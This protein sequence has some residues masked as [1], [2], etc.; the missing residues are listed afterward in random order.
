[1]PFAS[2]PVLVAR[3]PVAVEVAG[4]DTVLDEPLE[5]VG[6]DG[7]SD[8][9]VPPELVEA[10]DPAERV[11]QD[12]DGPTVA[13]DIQ[14]RL[15]RAASSRGRSA[16]ARMHRRSVLIPNQ[17]G[18]EPEPTLP[19]AKS[20][21]QFGSTRCATAGGS[22]PW[23][24]M[25]DEVLPQEQD[26]DHDHE[27]DARAPP[28]GAPPPRRDRRDRPRH[29]VR[30]Q[31]MVWSRTSPSSSAW[32]PPHP[33]GRACS[34]P[35]WPGCSPGRPPWPRGEYV[36]MRA[37]SELVER[38]LEIERR[39]LHHQPEA[40]TRELASIYRTAGPRRRPGRGTGR[41]RHGRP[42]RRARGPRPAR[43]SASTPQTPATR[44]RQPSA[45]SSRSAWGAMVPLIPWFFMEGT[46]A[47]IVSAIV[48]FFAAAVVGLILA[49][50]TERSYFR[51][52]LRQV[53]VG[54]GRV[55]SDVRDRLLAGRRPLIS[56]GASEPPRRHRCR[57]S[58]HG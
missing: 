1:M 51:T 41:G 45:R 40:E 46:A 24:G 12:Q 50:F 23:T 10:A 53:T 57:P 47:I 32:R 30:R 9:E 26:H 7:P 27:G 22:L 19:A 11:A 16:I 49:R 31:R 36:S 29:R 54:G 42:R 8:I 43:N 4:E 37:Q 38:E 39:S 33:I 17:V 15:D 44:W 5:P 48:G 18:A 34:W 13:E 6:E 52:A 20:D 3:R 35:A 25:G 28:D 58:P 56:R 21:D 55:L 14:A 2:Q